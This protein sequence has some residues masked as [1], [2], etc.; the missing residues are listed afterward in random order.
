MNVAEYLLEDIDINVL[1]AES[2]MNALH[3]ASQNGRLDRNSAQTQ[4]LRLFL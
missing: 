2:E 1:N 3:V 4:Q